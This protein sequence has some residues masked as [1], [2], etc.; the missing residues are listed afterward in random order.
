MLTKN[1]LYSR[2]DV[3]VIGFEECKEKEVNDLMLK[4]GLLA[5]TFKGKH[6]VFMPVGLEMLQFAFDYE[7]L[8]QLVNTV[9]NCT[10]VPFKYFEW[11]SLL[12]LNV[13]FSEDGLQEFAVYKKDD[14]T[15]K[16]YKFESYTIS[17]MTEDRLSSL[18]VSADHSPI[19]QIEGLAGGIPLREWNGPGSHIFNFEQ[20][21]NFK[22][23]F[24]EF[25]STY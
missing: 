16:Y 21:K 11:N 7:G 22:K 5:L 10:Q 15:E 25:I 1:K 12:L 13:S 19:H 4:K 3:E 23:E 14:Q 6:Y 17:W 2:N 20:F 24:S 9:I 18:L 8:K